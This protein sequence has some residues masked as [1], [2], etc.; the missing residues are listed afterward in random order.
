[1]KIKEIREVQNCPIN[2]KEKPW[3]SAL[4]S[5]VGEENL[6][7]DFSD[8]LAYGRDRW[9][10]AT[11]RYRFGHLPGF[12]PLVV[13]MPGTVAEVQ[14]I[15][16][17][18]H[19]AR[20]TV[21][22]YGAG[23]GVLG[24]AAPM[25]PDVVM[26]DTKRL[27]TVLAVDEVSKLVTVQGGMN[28]ERFEAHMNNL[29]YTVGHL[30][31]S[32]NMSTVAGWA[33]CRGAGQASGK[34]GKIEDIVAGMKVVLPNGELLEIRPAPRRAVGPGL[35]ELIIGSE[36]TFG[37]IVELTM[38]FW[39]YPK[40]EILRTIGFKDY[41]SGLEALRRIMQLGLK[42]PVTRLYDASESEPR[43]KD[44]PDFK[45]HPCLCMLM[46]Q[47]DPDIVAL[48]DKKAMEIVSECGG[49][50]CCDDP[51]HVWLEH[52]FLPLSANPV[53]Q[54]NLMDTCE[55]SAHWSIMPEVYENMREAALAVNPE[56]HVG[57]HWS[58]SYIDG[59]CLYMT[60]IIPGMDE[61][62]AADEH[63]RI[64]EG[65]T[66]GAQKAGGAMSHHHGVGC[67]R[68]KWMAEEW[69]KAGINVLQQIK[70]VIDPNHIMNP[71]KIGLR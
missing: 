68:G 32:L 6:I 12:L 1:M 57:A 52:R 19:D 10:Y 42:P 69:G 65:L 29:R 49:R 39:D 30:P 48:E 60:F 71:G 62:K 56:A 45:D 17:L 51:A 2:L 67:M 31:Q 35:M 9:P 40:K 13:A 24:G 61:E 28:G 22:A 70:N 23:S 53:S 7:T 4:A 59:A 11:M 47:G 41:L 58:H 55:V 64:W 3:F 26:I 15:M 21:I 66:C 16:R 18:M 37:I 33:A 36:G 43:V 46:F 20:Q 8:R 54:G 25:S 5:I 27:N 44:Y 14:A 63:A 34:Y 50:L 38:R